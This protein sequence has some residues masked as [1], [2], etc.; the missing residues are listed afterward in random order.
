MQQSSESAKLAL[1]TVPSIENQ[2]RDVES[3]VAEAENVIV[4][5]Q[6]IWSKS[7]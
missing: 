5:F 7:L 2:I 3:V 4:I 1:E 6:F